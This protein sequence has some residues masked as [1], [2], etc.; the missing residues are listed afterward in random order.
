MPLVAALLTKG[1]LA[2]M[3]IKLKGGEL[4]LPSPPLS[5]GLG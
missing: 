2:K 3:Q 1:L 5:K 4:A